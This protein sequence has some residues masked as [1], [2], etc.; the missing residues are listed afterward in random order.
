MRTAFLVFE[1]CSAQKSPKMRKK[2]EKLKWKSLEKVC[3]TFGMNLV[4]KNNVALRVFD[5]KS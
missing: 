4:N 1:I 3:C 2:D 5:N